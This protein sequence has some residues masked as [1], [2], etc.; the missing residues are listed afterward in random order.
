[1]KKFLNT[2][3][4]LFF[5]WHYFSVVC[6]KSEKHIENFA[7]RAEKHNVN[8]VLALIDGSYKQVQLIGMLKQD[9]TQFLNECFA[10]KI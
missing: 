5:C 2:Y 7:K 1:M 6:R 8:G 4:L 10:E 9:T 3:L